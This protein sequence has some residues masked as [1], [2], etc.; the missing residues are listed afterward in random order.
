[1][2][3]N[4]NMIFKPLG[5]AALVVGMLGFAQQSALA[6]NNGFFFGK[7]APG[8]WTIGAKLANVN[9]NVEGV[10][11]ADAV[12]IVLGYEF[13]SSIGGTGGSA[14]VEFEYI[15]ADDTSELGGFES[16]GNDPIIG[17]RDRSIDALSYEADVANLFFTYRSPGALYYK[18]KGGLSYA[19]IDVRLVN[20]TLDNNED[21]S[22]AGGLGLGYR[23][24]DLGVVE[25]EYSG[26]TGDSNLGILG[27]NALLQF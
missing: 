26:D 3:R 1:M 9:P 22:I 2:K 19:S 13:A 25:V 7:D 17:G 10:K 21:V 14:S 27:V 23:V 8:K 6:Q 15:S 11:D 24:G 20:G 16:I 4:K 5:K 12:G 18:V